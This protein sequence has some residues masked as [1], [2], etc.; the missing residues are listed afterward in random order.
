MSPDTPASPVPGQVERIFEQ[1]LDAIT[2]YADVVSLAVTDHEVIVQF[3]EPVPGPP[4]AGGPPV[5]R[6][7]LRAT[8]ILTKEHAGKL[9]NNLNLASRDTAG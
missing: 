6:T 9:A 5:M 8:V 2:C 4:K 1:P 7:R 3:Y